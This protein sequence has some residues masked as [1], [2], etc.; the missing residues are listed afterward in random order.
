MGEVVTVTNPDGQRWTGRL[1][2]THELSGPRVVQLKLESGYNIGVKVEP[3]AQVDHHAGLPRDTPRT[4]HPSP[5][6][7]PSPS[8]GGR[9]V[10]VLTTGGT[11]ASR[12]DYQTGGVRPVTDE[13]EILTFYPELEHSGPVRVVHVFDKLSEDISP[14]DWVTL[15]DQVVAAFQGGAGGVVIAHGTDTLHFTASALA[16]LLDGLPGPVVLVGAQRSPDRPSSDGFTNMTAAV[17]VARESSLFEVV[18]V[19]HAGLSDDRWAIHRG[20]RVRKMHAS[21]RDAF[22]TRNGP[23]L[24]VLAGDAVAW[25]GTLRARSGDVVTVSRPLGAPAALLWTHPGL[26][27]TRA[28]GFVTGLRGVVIAGTG[29]GHTARDH[30][31][32]IRAATAR[33][34]VVAMT[35]QCLAGSVD[36]YV[37]ATGRELLEAG[38]V[39]AGDMLPETAY[40]KMLWALGQGDDPSEVTR[41]FLEDRAGER[42][43]RHTDTEAVE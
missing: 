14:Q 5:S 12:V 27:P 2:P 8:A 38:V 36:P 4:P 39:F 37:Y 6:G 35:T 9:P 29:L 3:G 1:M 11:I 26:E 7:A 15:A 24:G 22:S 33:G 16:F 34:V 18:V 19:M 10:V 17:R 21:R 42:V 13:R 41:R 43:T 30:L 25:Q 23:P 31:S 28:E 40:V 32:W 20:T